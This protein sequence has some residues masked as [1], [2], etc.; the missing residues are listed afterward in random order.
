[1]SQSQISLLCHQALKYNPSQQPL[2]ML[3]PPR[4]LPYPRPRFWILLDLGMSPQ[5]RILLDPQT[6]VLN[7]PPIYK[8]DHS[9]QGLG[10]G[11]LHMVHQTVHQTKPLHTHLVPRILRLSSTL[12]NTHLLKATQLHQEVHS[13]VPMGYHLRMPTC[14]RPPSIN[15]TLFC[16]HHRMPLGDQVPTLLVCHLML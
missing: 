15:S 13:P 5:R 7:H 14:H 6:M 11:S 10:N 9:S 12:L 1:M 2:Q 8:V 3:R 16:C 4:K